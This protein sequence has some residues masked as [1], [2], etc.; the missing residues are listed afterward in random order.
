MSNK[1]F[2]IDILETKKRTTLIGALIFFT[3]WQVGQMVTFNFT[4][5]MSSSVK[6]FFLLL[7]MIGSFGWVVVSIYYVKLASLY[8]KHPEAYKQL[9]DERSTLVAY[10][11]M[12]H[13]YKVT[14]VAAVLIFV[15][16]FLLNNFSTEQYGLTGMFVSHLLM[17]IAITSGWLAYLIVDKEQ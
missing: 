9:N 4:D 11:A 13:G 10:K 12:G 1:I 6:L 7:T 5:S 2:T 15:I 17:V 16:T 8:K 3:A 14:G